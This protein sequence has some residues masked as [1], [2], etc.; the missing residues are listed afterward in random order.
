MPATIERPAA[1][2]ITHDAPK[3]ITSKAQ[4]DA[5]VAWLVSLQRKER[6][7]AEELEISKLLAL[8]IHA[9]EAK[10]YTF[11]SASPVEVLEHLMDANHLKQKDL[12]EIFGGE[13]VVS[14]VLRG[15]RELN[16][17]QIQ[18]LSERFNVSPAVF[19]GK[20]R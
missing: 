18:R 9:Y 2:Y 4:H 1:K 20:T 7:T 3:I 6:R 5:Y 10:Q 11:K 14:L 12:A 17:H 15:R 19:V 8:V 13:S 16:V